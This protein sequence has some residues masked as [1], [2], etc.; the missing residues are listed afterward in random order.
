MMMELGKRNRIKMSKTKSNYGTYLKVYYLLV[1]FYAVINIYS[2]LFGTTKVSDFI[3]MDVTFRSHFGMFF[4]LFILGL[5]IITFILIYKNK[6]PIFNL[7][8]PVYNILFFIIWLNIVPFMIL[9][10]NE[11]DIAILILD[12]ITNYDFLFYFVDLGL[13]SYFLY[14]L[15]RNKKE[16]IKDSISCH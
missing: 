6:L 13:S 14:K 7:V 12:N 15:S 5:S 4:G 9:F 2:G 16:I 11:W 8:Y 3:K 10:N 1:L